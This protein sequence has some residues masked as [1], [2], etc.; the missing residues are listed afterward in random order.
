M[1]RTIL[2]VCGLAAAGG[3]GMAGC[4]APVADST[5]EEASLEPADVVEAR[6]LTPAG[7]EEWVGAQCPEDGIV[8]L[9]DPGTGRVVHSMS[10]EDVRGKA[11]ADPSA[12]A[13]LV[14]AYQAKVEHAE[15]GEG[16]RTGAT[17]EALT[18]IGGLAC[19]LV[20]L[21]PGLIFGWPGRG[22]EHASNPDDRR[23]CEA[24][25]GGFSAGAGVFCAIAAFF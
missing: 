24:T 5:A 8:V 2:A 22:C 4:V 15:R 18:T 11:L 20:A 10:C 21:G 13:S 6:A 9:A 7:F 14:Q 17:S 3:L 23:T 25:T 12:R 1:N 19:A 16:E